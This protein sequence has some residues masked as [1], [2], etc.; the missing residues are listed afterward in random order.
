MLGTSDAWSTSCLTH[1][2]RKPVYHIL[3]WLISAC[4]WPCATP[5]VIPCIYCLDGQICQIIHISL[6]FNYVQIHSLGFLL[7]DPTKKGH[8][9]YNLH[10]LFLFQKQGSVCNP[11]RIFSKVLGAKSK[12]LLFLNI[13]GP[14]FLHPAFSTT[15][16]GPNFFELPDSQKNIR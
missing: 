12:L 5:C 15:Y 4:C 6:K 14:V 3:D 9:P 11:E 8:C 7:W 1:R 10:L 16:F 13:S 2:S